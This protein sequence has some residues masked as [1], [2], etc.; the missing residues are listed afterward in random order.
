MNGSR[1]RRHVLL[2]RAPIG[3]PALPPPAA[4]APTE[5]A[6]R[7]R[8]AFIGPPASS[9]PGIVKRLTSPFDKQ[10]CQEWQLFFLAKNFPSSQGKKKNCHDFFPFSQSYILYPYSSPSPSVSCFILFFFKPTLS[11]GTRDFGCLQEQEAGM[12]LVNTAKALPECPDSATFFSFFPPVPA[13]KDRKG[14]FCYLLLLKF[15]SLLLR[16]PPVYNLRSREH[17][18]T[19]LSYKKCNF[20]G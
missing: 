2:T 6:P 8:A 15:A 13:L 12:G 9:I 3:V 11:W 19:P 4:A 18:G 17:T 1:G 14:G 16:P 20:S 5:G 10:G 7:R